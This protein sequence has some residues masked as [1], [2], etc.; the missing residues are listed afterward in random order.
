MGSGSISVGLH[1]SVCARELVRGGGGRL[2]V[3]LAPRL[4]RVGFRVRVRVKGRVRDRARMRVRGRV[5]G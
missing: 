4:V 5:K 1:L 2:G 3:D